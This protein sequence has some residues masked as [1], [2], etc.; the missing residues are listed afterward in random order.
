MRKL[1]HPYIL[2]LVELHESVNSIY[3]VLEIVKGTEMYKSKDK[4][5]V[6]SLIKIYSHILEGVAYIHSKNIIHRDLKFQNIMI[7]NN[8]KGN[9]QPVIIDFGLALKTNTKSHTLKK[10]G[11]PGFVAP[12]VFDCDQNLK[13]VSYDNKVDVYCLGIMLYKIFVGKSPF[14][15][16]SVK[17]ILTKN[18]EGIINYDKLKK[19][20]KSLNHLIT[21]MTQKDPNMRLSIKQCLAHDFFIE[22]KTI[23]FQ[24][25]SISELDDMIKNHAK[26]SE[27][28]LKSI[29]SKL[30]TELTS[31]YINKNNWN[32]KIDTINDSLNLSNL[33]S[34]NKINSSSKVIRKETEK[35]ESIFKKIIKIENESFCSSP[36]VSEDNK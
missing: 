15:G 12:E 8:E 31:F 29:K 20:P 24:N 32:G 11:T 19:L 18:K 1:S 16:S 35:R 30:N 4:Y 17:E 21:N 7:R 33:S 36:S 5:D 22:Y 2:K 6:N 9:Y 28:K 34:N 26:N 27:I 14:S 23:E 10:C 25:D 13:K 3:L